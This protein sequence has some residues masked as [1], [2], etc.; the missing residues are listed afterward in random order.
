MHQKTLIQFLLLLAVLIISLVFYKTY[1][2]KKNIV[3]N[4]IKTNEDKKKQIKKESNFIES[5]KY[6]ST[7]KEGNGYIITSKSGTLDDNQ[8]E[9]I[10][11]KSVIATINLHNSVPIIITADNAIYNNINYDTNFYENVLVTYNDHIISSD[12]LDLIFEKN[13]ATISNN[14]IYKNLNTKLQADK[15]EI[16]LITKNSKIFMKDKTK[17]IKIESIN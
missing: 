17:K 9:L 1:F 5:I 14:I 4:K 3:S 16:D 13:L 6:T 11:M 15:V 10:L 8:P 12:N 7:D 2:L